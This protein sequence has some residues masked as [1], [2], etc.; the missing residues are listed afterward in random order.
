MLRQ[1]TSL[2][3]CKTVLRTSCIGRRP[4]TTGTVGKQAPSGSASPPQPPTT[5]AAILK[6]LGID[7]G[8]VVPGVYYGKR[9]WGGAGEIL[10]SVDPSTGEVIGQVQGV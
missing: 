3:R 5:A 8:K 1:L 4:L 2:T 7:A 6:E 10:T 9:Q